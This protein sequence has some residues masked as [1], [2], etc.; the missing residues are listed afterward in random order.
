MATP[1]QPFVNRVGC[2]AEHLAKGAVILWSGLVQDV[3]LVQVTATGVTLFE[4]DNRNLLS[5]PASAAK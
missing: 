3:K 2:T 4:I 5:Q 1:A